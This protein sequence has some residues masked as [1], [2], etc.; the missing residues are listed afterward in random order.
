MTSTPT[1]PLSRASGMFLSR[2]EWHRV[3]RVSLCTL[4]VLSR[5]LCTHC[6]PPM[7]QLDDSDGLVM[8][9]TSLRDG[10]LAPLAAGDELYISYQP[11]D[12]T[13]LQAFIKFGYVPK[14]LW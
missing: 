12:L 2:A 3:T 11:D 7:L 1:H 13:P 9:V 4:T 8:T 6:R 14:E 10:E 5:S